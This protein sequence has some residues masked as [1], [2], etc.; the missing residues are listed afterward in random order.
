MQRVWILML[1][2]VGMIPLSHAYSPEDTALLMPGPFES[3]KTLE[4]SNF[5]INYQPAQLAY[6]QR[7]AAIAETV[8][9]NLTAEFAW[10]PKS[11]I[12]V[13]VSDTYDGSNGGASV[14]PYNR[15]FIFM[16]GPVE[17]EL[18]D[19]APWIEQVFTHE[20]IHILHLD[21][22]EG[23]PASLRHVFGRMFF[24]FPQAFSPSWVSEGIAVYGETNRE[25]GFG[26]G[27]G[28]LYEAMMRAELQNGFRSFT[29]ESYQGYWGTDWPGGQVYLYG[30]YFF[31]FIEQ[32]YGYD[33]A[34][35]YLSNWN[36]NIVPW[37]MESRARQTF[38]LSARQLWNEFVGYLT[39][40]FSAQLAAISPAPYT[41]IVAHG[42]VN[43][44]PVWQQNGD[45][46]YY[47]DDG[48]NKPTIEKITANGQTKTVAKVEKFS[49]L[50]VHP[51]AGVLIS[52][53]TICDNTKVFTDL[54][55]LDDRG[56]WHRIT[57][58]G[59]YPRMAWSSDGKQ[60]A[61]VHVHDGLNQ[62]AILDEHGKQQRLFS[63]LMLGETIGQLDWSPDDKLLVASVRREKT[64]W[65]LEIM[66]VATGEWKALTDNEHLEQQPQFSSDG[67]YVYFLSDQ[68]KVWNVR[69]LER[70]SGK[71]ETITATT[72]AVMGY[73]VLPGGDQVRTAEYTASGIMLQQQTIVPLP[74]TYAAS[75]PE[76]KTVAS[77]VNRT[78]YHP[79]QYEIIS[80]YSPLDTLRPYSWFTYFYADTEDNKALQLLVN[81]QDVLGRHYWQLA[82]TFYLDKDQV[83]GSAA[84]IAYHRLALLWDS[85]VDVKVE[86]APGVLEQ[87]DTENRY[88]AVWMQ[89]FN[90]FDGTF[91]IDIGVGSERVKQEIQHH[92]TLFQFDDNFAGVALSWADYDLYLHSVSAE[93]GRWIKLNLEKYDVLGDA[94]HSGTASTLD[95]REYV[96]LFGN[97]VLALRAVIGSADATAKPYELGNELDQFES[98]GALI[99]FGKTG[100]T[101][102]GYND[103]AA[104]LT[105]TNMRLFSAEWRLPLWELFDGFSVPPL[106]LGKSALHL[107]VDHGAAWNDH[108]NHDYY[109]GVGL[110]IQPDLLVGY[111]S[112]K[113]DSTIG[114]A[115]GLDDELGKSTVYLRLGAS[116]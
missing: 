41:D 49:T 116:F 35:A 16:N 5:R 111:S 9:A 44:D 110:E 21:Q 45:F 96:G 50:D 60:I 25:K 93:D 32:R 100:Y 89:P 33:K 106:G 58:C 27:Q 37:R 54:F 26:R 76:H 94:Y 80:D 7:V 39:K 30:Y 52:R 1:M 17:G 59:R 103:G 67:K 70:V 68:N 102:R 83:G 90:S 2:V 95:W 97:H 74:D 73:A 87:W 84:Y 19:N 57:H 108:V 86:S 14:L 107:F 64:G 105:G 72:T 6:A 88:Q 10:T 11:K 34:M 92:G 99:G 81:G 109:T 29:Q 61:A 115:Q 38:G 28:A 31:E 104:Q 56:L 42:R 43:S 101:L 13:V 65:N 79:A 98:L 23:L 114:Y 71:V 46:Y 55:R 63:P 15:F 66:D 91:R 48:S 36:S 78:D 24:N 3:W 53:Y 47:R 85:T 77:I 62:I 8:F 18:L 20:L 4:T 69:R 12:E 40:K 22:A 75:R 113:L 82:P 51:A 112:L